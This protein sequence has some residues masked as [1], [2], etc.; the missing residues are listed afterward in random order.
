MKFL[1]WL[2]SGFFIRHKALRIYRQGR[3]RAKKKE[4]ERAIADY[5]E[6]I[7][8]IAVPTDVKAMALYHRALA[9]VASGNE[10]KGVED[11]DSVLLMDGALVVLNIKTMARQ[12]L[13]K[14]KPEN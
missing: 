6:A 13:I 5:T 9:Y 2:R 14:I 1:G 10:G 4:L 12:V 11:L 3:R 7:E 8:T